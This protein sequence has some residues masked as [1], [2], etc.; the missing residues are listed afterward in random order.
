MSRLQFRDRFF[1]RALALVGFVGAI[2]SGTRA[3]SQPDW[4]EQVLAAPTPEN[5]AAANIMLLDYEQVTYLPQGKA[6]E[7]VRGAVK[8]LHETG[9]AETQERLLTSLRYNANTDHIIQARAWIVSADGKHTK[10]HGKGDFNDRSVL[11]SQLMWDDRRMISFVPSEDLEVGGVIAWEYEVE[12][13]SGILDSNWYFQS[14]MPVV[15]SLF[16]V[17]PCPGGTLASHVNSSQIPEATADTATGSLKWEMSNVPATGG[18]FLPPGFKYKPLRA[19]VRCISPDSLASKIQTWADFADMTADVIEPRI[20]ASAAVAE[21]A[22]SLVKGKTGRWD[23]IRA[24]T[25]FVQKE[26]SYLSIMLDKD[27]LAGY[28]PQAPDQVM[29]CRLGDCKDKATLVV[30]MLRSLGEKAYVVV[31]NSGNP[32]VVDQSWPAQVFNHAI[33]AIAADESV[34]SHWPQVDGG[35][36]GKLVLFDATDE[37]T[38]LGVLPESDQGGFG[39]VVTK[40]GPGLVKFPLETPDNKKITRHITGTVSANGD[41]LAEM[42]AT[43]TGSAAG[44]LHTALSKWGNGKFNQNMEA[45]FHDT[46]PLVKD[47]TW[48]E[49]WDQNNSQSRLAVHF[50]ASQYAHRL[51]EDLMLLCPHLLSTHANYPTWKTKIEG[52]VWLTPKCIHE[53]VRLHLPE[54]FAPE[55]LPSAWHQELPA[56][57]ASVQYRMEGLDLVYEY[58]LEQQGGAYDKNGYDSLRVFYQKLSEAE[59]RPIVLRRLIKAAKSE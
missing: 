22:A 26:I 36:L 37:D 27:S 51:A 47:L 59:R 21:K 31:L 17:I 19:S 33:V 44:E 24:I 35:S 13:E 10:S 4:L 8:I 7:L 55:D 20:P 6:H 23:R 1:R 43:S 40:A 15:K 48:K 39:V 28:R 49:S 11:V 34:P 30:S 50:A 52:I 2:L 3:A 53:D 29:Q 57:T 58:R 45:M 32:T 46:L 42:E 25:E 9:L 38:P 56:A 18:E 54:G 16:E 14:K 41:L 12:A 5:K